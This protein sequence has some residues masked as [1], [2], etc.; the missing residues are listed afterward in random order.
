MKQLLL[1][2]LCCCVIAVTKG[3]SDSLNRHLEEAET[4]RSKSQLLPAYQHY[5]QAHRL[6]S[7]NMEAIRGLAETAEELRYQSDAQAAYIKWLRYQPNDTAAIA[8]AARL[9]FNLRRWDDAIELSRKALTLGLGSDHE[10]IIAK[11]YFEQ[12]H[13]GNALEYLERA[14]ARDSSRGEIAFLAAR[15]YIEMSNY[16]RAAG[17]YEQ[18]LV[19]EPANTTWMYEAAMTYSAI[20]DDARAIG[21]YEKAA[22]AGYQKTNDFLENM[23]MSYIGTKQHGKALELI[24]E[25]LKRKPEDLELLYRAGEA[26]LKSGHYQEA[27]NMYDKMLAIDKN[28]PRAVYMIGYTYIQKGEEAKGKELCERAIQ[29]DPSLKRLR[30]KKSTFGL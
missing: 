14:W 24:H 1:T 22:A 13:Y 29:M 30:E 23:A 7:T 11:S 18:A 12:E 26:N 20:P 28:Q 17:C 4:Y 25:L 8:H 16:R 10:Y 27:I 6:D 5:K 3:Q 9:S 2:V 19:R 21:W 15:S